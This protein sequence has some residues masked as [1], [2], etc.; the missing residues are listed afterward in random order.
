MTPLDVLSTTHAQVS[1]NFE[2]AHVLSVGIL[3]MMEEEQTSVG[4][5]IAALGLCLARLM[6]PA[7]MDPQD[8][9]KFVADLMDWGGAYFADGGS[10]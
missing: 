7:Q 3:D 5:G 1:I 2:N 8:E 10:N 9:A 4:L 6:S